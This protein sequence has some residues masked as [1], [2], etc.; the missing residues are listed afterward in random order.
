MVRT[1]QR[2]ADGS[3]VN[4]ATFNAYSQTFKGGVEVA[5]CNSDGGDDEIV[6]GPASGGASLI[7]TFDSSGKLK[8]RAFFAYDP[9]FTGGVHLACGGVLSRGFTA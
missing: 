4:L 2:K 6:T 1:F 9:S 8:G 3:Y 7:R 5:A